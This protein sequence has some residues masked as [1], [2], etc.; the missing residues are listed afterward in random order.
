MNQMELFPDV[1]T[2]LEKA[3]VIKNTNSKSGKKDRK[4][5]EGNNPKV[6]PIQSYRINP[7]TRMW[8]TRKNVLEPNRRIN[9]RILRNIAGKAWLINTII[10]L[11]IDKL[12]PFLK[13]SGDE[14]KRG[15]RVVLNDKERKIS[16]EEKGIAEYIRKFILET[17]RPDIDREDDLMAYVSKIIR[18]KYTLDQV[19][20]EIQRSINKTPYAFW[21]I[22]P[23]TIYRVTEEGYEGNDKIRYVQEVEGQIVAEYTYQNFIFQYENPRSDIEYSGYGYSKV[24]QAVD[25]ITSTINT[26]MFNS[27]VFTEDYLPRGMILL[28]GDADIETVQ[29]MEDYMIS[30]MSGGPQNKWKIPIIPS[31]VDGD[32]SKLQFVNFQNSNRDMQFSEWTEFLWTS[33]AA[34]FGTDLEE[35]GIKTK[36]STSL[37]GDNI[38]PRLETSKSRALNNN[39]A[40]L[41]SHFNKIIQ[42]I[43]DRFCIEFTGVE[44][45]DVK[46]KNETRSSELSTHKSVNDLIREVDGKPMDPKEHPWAEIKGLGSQNILQAWLKTTQSKAENDTGNDNNQDIT[47]ELEKEINNLTQKDMKKAIEILI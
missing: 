31:G 23:A 5:H 27:G 37:L 35:L 45:E 6:L 44:R 43:D 7:Y 24:E 2:R 18:D 30:V 9:Y 38:G 13:I 25:L 3:G 36:Q 29:A 39:L 12:R 26:F 34:L 14:N 33:V 20:T 4:D 41:E 19:T 47:N 40:F 22:D 11:Q 1:V 10:G 17:G 15:F 42:K 28:D 46:L 21:A 32:K 16:T 8:Q